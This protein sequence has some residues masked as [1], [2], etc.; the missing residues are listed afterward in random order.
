MATEN[1]VLNGSGLSHLTELIK[2]YIKEHGGGGGS[3]LPDYPTDN[4]NYSLIVTVNGEKQTLSWNP[5]AGVWELPTKILN[6]LRLHQAVTI[7]KINNK[8]EVY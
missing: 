7:N 4:G 6:D 3:S 1:K 2:K 5:I 8:L